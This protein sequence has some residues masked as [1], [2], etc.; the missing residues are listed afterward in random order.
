MV[1]YYVPA[2][3]H[4]NRGFLCGKCGPAFRLFLSR[5]NAWPR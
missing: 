3:E 5:G 4:R 2:V 1:N